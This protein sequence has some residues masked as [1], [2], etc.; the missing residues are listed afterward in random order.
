[1]FKDPTVEGKKNDE[2]NTQSERE[3]KE[4]FENHP[5]AIKNLGGKGIGN[6]KSLCKTF[7]KFYIIIALQSFET[8]ALFIFPLTSKTRLIALVIINSM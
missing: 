7:S 4:V 5:A 8:N 6:S 1:M 2:N 3:N